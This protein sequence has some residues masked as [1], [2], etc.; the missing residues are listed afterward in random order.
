MSSNSTRNS[1]SRKPSNVP[2]RPYPEYPMG[3][4]VNGRWQKRIKG[5][6]YYFGRWGRM[7]DGAI[8]QL[9]GDDWWKPALEIFKA[10]IDG[11]HAG[12]GQV[13]TT[14]PDPS[15]LTVAA[16]CNKFLTSKLRLL[17]SAEIVKRTF[18][19]YR[20][21]CDRLVAEFGKQTVVDDLTDESFE[22]LRANIARSWGP[23]RLSNEV[24]RVRSVFKR[25]R[26]LDLVPDE[27]R[28]PSRKVLRK[29]RAEGG[30]RLF[31]AEEIH[32]L[33]DAASVTM[34]GMLLLGINTG[35][36]G[37]DCGTLPKHAVDLEGGWIEYARP[38][39]GVGRRCKLWPET[40][41]ALR[42]A[43]AKR[44]KAKVQAD[45]A[46]VFLTRHGQPWASN[47]KSSPVSQEVGKLLRKLDVNGRRGLGF[48]SLRHTFRTVADNCK[49]FPAIRV[50]MGHAD[51]SIDDV[52]REG[53]DD[54][55]L[56]SVAE[57]VRAWLFGQ[58][59]GAK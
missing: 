24:T 21:T 22:T 11:I 45:D 39:T 28:K 8:V 2:K 34:R 12:R 6:L 4:H 26:K 43:I 51:G 48:Y 23:V 56:E 54:A 31:S 14:K 1:R 29:H 49:D 36:G 47:S 55:R 17:E 52:Y 15:Q 16:M 18:E 13:D 46:L 25:G 42:E 9:E 38:K 10:Q 5:K 37:S 53:I 30:K 58:E 35:F 50:V 40:I 32:R 20:G 27:F 3:P 44:P 7:I 41:A 59:G 19:D 33:L 57:F